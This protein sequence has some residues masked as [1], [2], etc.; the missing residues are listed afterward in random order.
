VLHYNDRDCPKHD[1]DHHTN[2]EIE[3][4]VLEEGGMQEIS[5]DSKMRKGIIS[6][7]KPQLG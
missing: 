3:T 5:F 2:N 7:S 4:T 6:G 1:V